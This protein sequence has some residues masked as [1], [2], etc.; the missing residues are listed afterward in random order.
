MAAKLRVRVIIATPI[1]SL[2]NRCTKLVDKQLAIL[3]NYAIQFLGAESKVHHGC[4]HW[5]L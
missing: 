3:S 2:L 1:I 4:D 5:V